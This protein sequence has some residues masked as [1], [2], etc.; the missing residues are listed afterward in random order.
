MER[1]KECGLCG[2]NLRDQKSR[3]RGYGP[4]CWKK[5][6]EQKAKKERSQQKLEL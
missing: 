4:C 5:H 1:R 6:I 3:A 2:R